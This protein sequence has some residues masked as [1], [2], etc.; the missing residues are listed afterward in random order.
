MNPIRTIGR[1][2]G[3]LTG[4]AATL[5]AATRPGP[6]ARAARRHRPATAAWTGRREAAN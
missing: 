5:A 2:A 6:S 1:L 3:M 4:L